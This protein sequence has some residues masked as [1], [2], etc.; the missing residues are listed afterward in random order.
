MRSEAPL[1]R[2]FER[3]EASLPCHLEQSEAESRDLIARDGDLS[4]TFAAF[5]PLKMTKSCALLNQPPAHLR[6]QRDNS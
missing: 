6:F 1:P 3:S 5:A 2:H 4:T